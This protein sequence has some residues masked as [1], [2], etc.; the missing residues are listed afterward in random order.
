MF[1]FEQQIV[2]SVTIAETGGNFATVNVTPNLV[3]R[4]K[5]TWGGHFGADVW[6]PIYQSFATS[7]RLGAFLRYAK[8]SSEMLVVS[9]AI[10]TD[11]GGVQYGGG[12]RFRF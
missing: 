12:I 9:N 1:R 8:A 7:V 3:T 4:K 5:S 2:D 6:Y 10:D 11:V